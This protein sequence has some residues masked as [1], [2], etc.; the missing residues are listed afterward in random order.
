MRK[1]WL[2]VL[3]LALWSGTSLGVLI[4][5]ILIAQNGIVWNA[6]PRLWILYPEIVTTCIAAVVPLVVIAKKLKDFMCVR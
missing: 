4:N 2:P 6:E 3:M 1:F 5:L